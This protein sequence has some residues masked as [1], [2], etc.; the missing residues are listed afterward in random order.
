MTRCTQRCI[1]GTVYN[2]QAIVSIMS[3]PSFPRTQR[4]RVSAR[5]GSSSSSDSSR[6]Q[7]DTRSTRRFIDALTRD[8]S[9]PYVS[10]YGPRTQSGQHLTVP[11]P[12]Q[13][14]STSQPSSSQESRAAPMSVFS[15]A[16]DH[17]SYSSPGPQ[18]YQ[19]VTASMMSDPRNLS[20]VCLS[21]HRTPLLHS[22]VSAGVVH[23]S[24]LIKI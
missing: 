7:Q 13:A 18:D 9:P 21:S 1:Q 24:Y 16:S 3:Y 19:V 8:T 15:S 5:D 12:W 2:L 11:T 22:P 14:S 23:L 4:Q 20:A 17:G 10:P 6:L